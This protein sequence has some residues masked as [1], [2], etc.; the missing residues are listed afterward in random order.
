MPS[1]PSELPVALVVEDDVDQRLLLAALL[2]LPGMRVLQCD[3]AEDAIRLL[4][5]MNGKVCLLL[6][7]VEL[8]GTMNGAALAAIT[9]RRFPWIRLIVSSGAGR[10]K[11]M[12]AGAKFIPKPWVATEILR[13]A[14]RAAVAQ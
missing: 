12:P 13:E 1:N 4:D 10:P 9:E 14:E 7:D 6:T 11:A 5:R 8:S 2:E 3:S